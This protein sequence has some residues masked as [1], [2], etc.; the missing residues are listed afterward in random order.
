MT[1]KDKIRVTGVFF[2]L[3]DGLMLKPLKSEAGLEQ[4]LRTTTILL[5]EFGESCSIVRNVC[6]L[7]FI[8]EI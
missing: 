8:L 5:L 3:N 2:S 7:F 1:H 6:I 4:S